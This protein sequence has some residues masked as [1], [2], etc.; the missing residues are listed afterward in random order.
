MNESEHKH[1]LADVEAIRASPEDILETMRRNRR[2]ELE[3]R[4]HVLRITPPFNGTHEAKTFVSEDGNL[5]PPDMDPRPIHIMPRAFLTGDCEKPLPPEFRMPRVSEV[6]SMFKDDTDAPYDIETWDEQT[7]DEFEAYYDEHESIW[8]DHVR[9][10]L[11]DS[12][13]F[14]MRVP[15]TSSELA[16]SVYVSETVD[17]TYTA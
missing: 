11:Q 6:R 15:D 9:K 10:S 5:Y 1:P 16:A 3:N 13:L 4:T 8:E 14:R 2:D 12:I 7:H 17:I